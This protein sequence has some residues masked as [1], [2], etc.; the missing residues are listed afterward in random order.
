MNRYESKRAARKRGLENSA[1]KAED[2]AEELRSKSSEI[3][4]KMA[5]TP[6]IIGHHSEKRHRRDLQR[7]WDLTGKAINEAARSKELQRRADAVGHGGISSDDPDALA[8]LETKL[9]KLNADREGIKTENRRRR[10][11]GEETAPKWLLA[12]LG[13]NIRNVQKRI[14]DMQAESGKSEISAEGKGWTCFEHVEDNR[15]RFEFDSK[16]DADTRSTLKRCGFRWSPTAGAWQRH[17]N[18]AGRAAALR[19]MDTLPSIE[20]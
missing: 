14:E 15:I 16:P 4:Q 8:K 6:V 5:G 19:V 17:K 20:G 13:A 1:I 10:K 7:S 3:T 18:N 2:K 11:A 9:A 12:N